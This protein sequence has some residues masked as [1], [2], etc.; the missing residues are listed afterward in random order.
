M[1]E[2]FREGLKRQISLVLRSHPEFFNH[3]HQHPWLT[4]ALGDPQSAV[5]FVGENPSLGQVERVQ[6]PQGGPPTEEAQW[7]ASRGDRLFRDMLVTHGFKSPPAEAHGG[8]ACYITNVIKEAD[9]AQ[10]WR[11]SPVARRRAAAI[12]WA[13]VL[14]WE[15][16]H[17]NPRVVVA[18]GKN[19]ST[20]LKQLEADG[21]VKLPDLKMVQHYS[22]VAMRPR[23]RLGP[24]H[25]QRVA[26]Y[27]AEFAEIAKLA[28]ADRTRTPHL[29]LD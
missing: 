3:Y 18:L 12:A 1:T 19:V 8:W 9:Y 5:W 20:T 10:R 22:Y 16:S 7:W 23:G 29:P 2:D 6:D 24:M 13:P 28:R 14:R 25:P 26:E 15:L 11:E 27:D 4:G 17:G 21:L